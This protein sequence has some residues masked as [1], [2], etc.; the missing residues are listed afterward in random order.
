[1]TPLS[2]LESLQINDLDRPFST[3]FSLLQ[4]CYRAQ[5][6]EYIPELL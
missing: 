5:S 3:M 4:Q 6:T 1:M 2:D